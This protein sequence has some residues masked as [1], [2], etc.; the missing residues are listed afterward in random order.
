MQ[1]ASVTWLLGLLEDGPGTENS[2]KA[3]WGHI[4]APNLVLSLCPLLWKYINDMLSLFTGDFITS[5][6]DACYYL[7]SASSQAHYGDSGINSEWRPKRLHMSE[8]TVNISRCWKSQSLQSELAGALMALTK[9]S[10]CFQW[11]GGV[12]KQVRSLT[13]HGLLLSSIVLVFL[14]LIISL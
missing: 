9:L 1:T 2:V 12:R 6:S 11:L 7:P 3:S 13:Q 5:L 10:H 4:M 8:E 14:K